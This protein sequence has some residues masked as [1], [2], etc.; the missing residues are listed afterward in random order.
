MHIQLGQIRVC[1]R[2]REAHTRAPDADISL[3]GRILRSHTQFNCNRYYLFSYIGFCSPAQHTRLNVLFA[4]AS[5]CCIYIYIY[6]IVLF[7]VRRCVYIVY[8]RARSPREIKETFCISRFCVVMNFQP[9]RYTPRR[10]SNDHES[11]KDSVIKVPSSRVC[12]CLCVLF[13][14]YI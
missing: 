11:S 8:M 5:R 13:S 6:F 12:V 7:G 1:A 2:A 4:F 10:F 14:Y 3:R 9:A